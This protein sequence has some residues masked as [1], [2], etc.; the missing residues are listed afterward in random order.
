[1]AP[2]KQ[3]HKERTQQ[4]VPSHK[5]AA[6]RAR[7]EVDLEQRQPPVG[8]IED[9]DDIREVL[10]QLLEGEG[11]AVLEAADGPA[12]LD[13]LTKYPERM[14][15]LVDHKLPALDGCDLLDIVAKDA[16]LRARHAIIFV[17]ASPRLAEQACGE[18]L[19]ELGAPLLPK[20]FD[21]D[22]VLDAVAEAA[23]RLAAA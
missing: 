1:M 5:T 20:P 23:Q 18:T 16:A 10:R 22:D 2:E 7:P 4:Q 19:E 8:V 9:N 21:I 12:G 15:V 3:A 17:T 14:I 11:Y 6:E 13:L